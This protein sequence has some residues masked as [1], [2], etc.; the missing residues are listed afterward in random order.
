MR[1]RSVRNIANNTNAIA[2][3]SY[4]QVAPYFETIEI[5]MHRITL[6]KGFWA[7]LIEVFGNFV[8]F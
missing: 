8:T 2:I 3:M 4:Q 1:C 7:I 6:M 5:D